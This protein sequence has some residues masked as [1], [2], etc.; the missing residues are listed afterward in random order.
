MPN[1]SSATY[2]LLKSEDKGLESRQPVSA[3][4][5]GSV[6]FSPFKDGTDFDD[7]L[8][9]TKADLEF[10]EPPRRVPSVLGALAYAGV[11]LSSDV[12][13]CC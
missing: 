13:D 8:F 1:K 6:D 2:F 3:L 11:S 12:E 9:F 5:A 10:Y 7:W 4:V